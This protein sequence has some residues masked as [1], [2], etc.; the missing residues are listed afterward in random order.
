MEW[1]LGIGIILVILS[2]LKSLGN[3]GN[4]D[5]WKSVRKNPQLAAEFFQKQ[6]EWYIAEKPKDVDV[7]GPFPFH[8]PVRNNLVN[9]YCESSKIQ[10]SQERFLSTVR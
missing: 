7:M 10:N 6:P 2:T 5:F 9:L 8:D 3:L 1:L 4:G